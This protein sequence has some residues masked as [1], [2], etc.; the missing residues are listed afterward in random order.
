MNPELVVL[1][2]LSGLFAAFSP[3]SLPVYPLLLNMMSRGGGD[4]RILAAAFTMGFIG[5][6]MLFYSIL[7]AAIRWLGSSVA[8]ERL[9]VIYAASE[10]LAALV[11][12]L[13]ALQSLGRVSVWG[14]TCGMRPDVKPG[15]AG[16]FIAGML[17]STVVTPCNLPF[18]VV[19]VYPLLM[20]KATALEGLA[21][22]LLFGASMS[23]PMLALGFASDYALKRVTPHLKSIE[24]VSAAFLLAAAAYF[25]YLASQA[26][27]A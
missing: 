17:F 20:A 22:M 1:S 7:A 21:L 4:R 6:F 12:V 14:R 9:E 15:L 18:L 8:A 23:L 3:C 5:M 10:A 25:L 11:C 13:F 26:I 19:G 2:M 24:L 27:P 16:A